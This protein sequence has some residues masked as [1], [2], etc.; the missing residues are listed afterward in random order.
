MDW[1]RKP[2][3]DAHDPTGV[4]ALLQ[5]AQDELGGDPIV[6]TRFL[7]DAEEMLR[8]T[9]EIEAA[10][11]GVHTTL[12]VGFQN[13]DKLRRE[14]DVYRDITQGGTSVLAFGEGAPQEAERLDNFSWTQL[15]EQRYALENQWYLITRDPEPIAFVGFEASPE[16]LRGEGGATDPAKTWEGF[17]TDD[18]R[19][20]DL[21][22]DHLET[23]ARVHRDD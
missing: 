1:Q 6:G 23:V 19:M 16:E 8:S 5:R 18:D 22:I 12:Y 7:H 11:S 3:D 13:G 2:R 10:V 20:I 17:V 14:F 9:R 4:T 15:P 21:I